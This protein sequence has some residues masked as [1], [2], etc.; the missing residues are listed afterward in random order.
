MHIREE[1]E[2]TEHPETEDVGEEEHASADA[3]AVVEV[4][5]EVDAEHIQQVVPGHSH[6]PKEEE[7]GEQ[8]QNQTGSVDADHRGAVVESGLTPDEQP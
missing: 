8:C 1:V 7:R 2:N 5:V 4:E 6:G 3:D